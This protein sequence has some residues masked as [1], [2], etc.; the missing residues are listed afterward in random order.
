M[1]LGGPNQCPEVQWVAFHAGKP[2]PKL[3]EA[4]NIAC[5]RVKDLGVLYAKAMVADRVL[6]PASVSKCQSIVPGCLAAV[7]DGG[8]QHW[9]AAPSAPPR[10]EVARNSPGAEIRRSPVFFVPGGRRSTRSL[11]S[12][13]PR[14]PSSPSIARKGKQNHL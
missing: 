6:R 13:P 7:A 3:M 5:L 11:G 14:E 9:E 4:W 1:A 8:T 12:P 10:V 2:A